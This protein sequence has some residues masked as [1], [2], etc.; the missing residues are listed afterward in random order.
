MLAQLLRRTLFAVALLAIAI[1]MLVWHLGLGPWAVALAIA[2]P[3]IGHLAL[4]AIA[5]GLVYRMNRHDPAPS[6]SLGQWVKAWWSEC[7]TELIVFAWRQPFR[8]GMYS[9]FLPAHAIDQTGVVLVHGFLCNRGFWQ[10]WVQ[11]LK[12]NGTPFIAVN[13]EPVFGSINHYPAILETA[14]H[15][16]IQ[17]T[18][19]PP[20]L[21]CHS[22]GGLVARAWLKTPGNAERVGH[23]VT[24]GTPHHG[25]ALSWRTLF[26][27]T[28]QM[29]RYSEWVQALAKGESPAIRTKMLCWYSQCDNIVAPASTATLPGAENRIVNG[30]GHCA[31]AYHPVVMRESLALR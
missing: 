13:L 14:V 29:E 10:P 1:A 8:S 28:R 15:A 25:T 2:A 9:D 19:R 12:A 21:V 5:F 20:L 30:L 22:M 27:N 11:P 4:M 31:L 6:L 23:L 26:A 17:A 18:G 16:M 24:I 7:L 3:L